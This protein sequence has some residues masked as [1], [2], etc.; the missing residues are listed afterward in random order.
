MVGC[1]NPMSVPIPLV[2][3]ELSLGL[4]SQVHALPAED[5]AC[6]L[7]M[8]GNL[9]L[10]VFEDLF[11]QLGGGD[12]TSTRRRVQVSNHILREHVTCYGY[13]LVQLSNHITP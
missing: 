5:C 1:S 7:R 9:R 12:R 11:V 4:R 6:S 3:Q 8:S 13:C 2:S 10:E